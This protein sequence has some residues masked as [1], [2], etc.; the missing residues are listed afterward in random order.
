[1]LS[2]LC[3]QAAL[4][5]ALPCLLALP[6]VAQ[7]SVTDIVER[8]ADAVV[9]VD[10]LFDKVNASGRSARGRDSVRVERPG[11]G[12]LVSESGLVLTNA[13]LVAEVREG[14]DEYWIAVSLATGGERRA[15]VVF[16]DETTDLALLQLEVRDSDHFVALPIAPARREEVGARV[17]ALSDPAGWQSR[18]AFAGALAFASGPV[19]L[20]EATLEPW[21]A[22]LSDCRFHD[23]LDGGPLLNTRGEVIGIHNSSHLSPRPEGFDE[24]SED[25]EKKVDL[26]YAVIVSGEAIERALGELLSGVQT[27]APVPSPTARD[28]VASAAIARIAPA[29]VSVWCA[30]EEDGEH[31]DLGDPADPQSQRI[32]ENLGSGVVVDPSGLVLACSSLFPET[33]GATTIRTADGTLYPATLVAR[34]PENQVALLKVSLPPDTSLTA[35][36]LA[37]SGQLAPGEFATVVARPFPAEVNMSVGVLSALERDGLVQLASWVHGGHRGGAVVD[38]QGRL[39]GIAV[40]QPQMAHD[41]DKDSY[42][43]FASPTSTALA[44]LAAEWTAQGATSTVQ[45]ATPEELEARRTAVAEVAARTRSSLINVMVKKAVEQAASGFDPFGGGGAR[46]FELLSQGSGVIIEATGLALSNWHVVDGALADD[47][48]QS[49]DYRIEVTLPDGRSFEARVLSTSRDDDLSLLALQIGP[50]DELVPVELGDSD[51]LRPGQPVIAI[52][53]PLGLANSVSAGIITALDQDTLIRGR[54]RKYN[55]MVMTDT[56][57]NP[58]NSGGALLDL[59]GRLVGINSAGRVGLGMAIPVDKAREVFSGKLLSAK[60]LRTA[61]LGLQVVERRGELVVD[62]L[63]AD[64][65]ARRAG[66]RI[67]DRVQALAGHETPTKAAWARVILDLDTDALCA[68]RVSREDE[69]HELELHPISFATWEIAQSCGIEVAAV[70]YAAES[71]LVLDASTALHRGYTQDPTGEP[72][73]SMAGALRVTRVG[74]LFGKDRP[75]VRPGDLLLGITSYERGTT[76]VHE[77][78]VRFESIA[79]LATAIAPLATKEG[80]GHLF[81]VLREGEVLTVEVFVRRPPR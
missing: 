30:G 41:V 81:W 67:A 33:G 22:L 34:K 54:L 57:I 36:T 77:R 11:S 18:Y 50:D 79:D 8:A 17:V 62:E 12:F 74:S 37:D 59:E 28:D 44:A 61:Y 4:T 72:T 75:L 26:D 76:A 19:K 47:G 23:L 16:R 3:R 63:D 31:P 64:G 55:G 24:E 68:L 5:L 6:A 43:G 7:T 52:G 42:L 70:D 71:Q 38:R 51:D 56:A 25:E 66:V 2:S 32:P 14:S 58:G 15:D 73:R 39:I 21:Q 48:T 46:S 27:L 9:S 1:M 69:V 20:R 29:V 13:H 35:A 53:N 45:T 60:S 49:P 40:Q 10:V 65:P 80:G 78:L